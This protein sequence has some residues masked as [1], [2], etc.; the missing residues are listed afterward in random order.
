MLPRQLR[1]RSRQRLR[2]P[3]AAGVC[4]PPP[5]ETP[6]NLPH[7]RRNIKK[8]AGHRP[9]SLSPWG[10]RQTLATLVRRSHAGLP[11]A[12]GRL[13]WANLQFELRCVP[14]RPAPSGRISILPHDRKLRP[15]MAKAAFTVNL[16]TRYADKATPIDLIK[17]VGALLDWFLL[18]V[19]Q[20]G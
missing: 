7:V 8:L 17:L 10:K 15:L 13:C 16:P 11:K 5:L 1:R 19:T 18:L 14:A 3:Q 6:M 2:N 20:A 12:H 4:A 9:S